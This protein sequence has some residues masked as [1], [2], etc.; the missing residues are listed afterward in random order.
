MWFGGLR[1]GSLFGGV[2]METIEQVKKAVDDGK[3]VNWANEI[4]VVERWLVPNGY[5]VRC[6]LNDFSS[7]LCQG[8]IK[9]CYIM[10]AL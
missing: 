4:Y 6:I 9:D 1:Y 8:N 10:G 3:L 7:P 2:V 5:Y